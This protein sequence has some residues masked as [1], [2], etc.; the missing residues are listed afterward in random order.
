MPNAT[1]SSTTPIDK[2]P[3]VLWRL[4]YFTP[5][6][7]PILCQSNTPDFHKCKQPPPCRNSN[8][9]QTSRHQSL[10]PPALL[11]YLII[12]F[13]NVIFSNDIW[14]RSNIESTASIIEPDHLQNSLL[15]KVCQ[16]AFI[17]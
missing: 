12:H 10:P 6:G 2:Y 4:F 1:T 7:E 9:S 15:A 14:D 5:I 17:R 3:S 8:A 13:R 11:K 16:L